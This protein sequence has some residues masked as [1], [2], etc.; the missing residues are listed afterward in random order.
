MTSLDAARAAGIAAEQLAE[1]LDGRHAAVLTG[2][3]VSTDSGIPDYRSPGRPVRNPMTWQEFER[4]DERRRR[5]WA[6]AAIGWPRF[7]RARPNAGHFALAELEAAELVTGLATQNIDGLHLE[8]GSARVVELHG[9]VR[10]VACTVCGAVESRAAL[11]T[12]MRAENPALAAVTSEV[13]GN[14]DGDAA[15]PETVVEA[16][17]VPVCLNCGGMLAPQVVMFGQFVPPTATEAAGRLIDDADALI[18]AGS[19][20]VVNTGIRLLHR[21][22]RR[23]LPVAVINRGPTRADEVATLRLDAGTSEALAGA[24]GL[25]LA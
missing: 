18:I 15:I 12:R 6:G 11:L 4:S 7:D 17:E 22:Q 1:F 21:A 24:A 14:P 3:G 10:S 25:L 8:A 13:E 16:F 19:S 20:M 9:H 23:G 2:A 5:Y